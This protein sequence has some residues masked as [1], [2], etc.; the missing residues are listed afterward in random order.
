MNRR[1]FLR[2]VGA[3]SIVSL[4]ARWMPGTQPETTVTFI[5]VDDAQHMVSSE[6]IRVGDEIM[7]VVSVEG[8]SLFVTRGPDG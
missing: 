6:Y 2:F 3:A 1:E 5:S 8:A 7:K 4:A